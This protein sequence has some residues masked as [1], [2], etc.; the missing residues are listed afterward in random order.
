MR[1]VSASSVLS[2]IFQAKDVFLTTRIGLLYARRIHARVR[3]YPFH[4]SPLH[5]CKR[6]LVEWGWRVGHPDELLMRFFGGK[7]RWY[8]T[9]PTSGW[10][11][12]RVLVLFSVRGMGWG[13]RTS[14]S[15]HMS[16]FMSLGAACGSSLLVNGPAASCNNLDCFRS[17]SVPRGDS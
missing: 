4:F 5:R 8:T 6:V 14:F 10:Q 11:R 7:V 12:L 13:S 1:L 2:K 9:P 17:R 16:S 3:C 15:V